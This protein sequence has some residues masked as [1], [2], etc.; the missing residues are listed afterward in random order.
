[1]NY[2]RKFSEISQDFSIRSIRGWVSGGN[3]NEM[4]PIASYDA[5]GGDPENIKPVKDKDGKHSAGLTTPGKFK[6]HHAGMHV[7]NSWNFSKVKWGVR[8]KESPAT[9]DVLY[10]D[11]P[12]QWHSVRKKLFGE[13][14]TAKNSDVIYVLMYLYERIAPNCPTRLPSTW[15]F[16]DFGHATWYMVKVNDSPETE[17]KP[18]ARQM[19]LSKPVAPPRPKIHNEFIHTTQ[20]NEYQ[21]SHLRRVILE[22]SHGCI[23]VKP[24][25]IDEMAEKG[26]L[27][28]GNWFIVHKYNEKPSIKIN[29]AAATKYSRFQLHFFPGLELIV[30]CG[31]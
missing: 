28:V 8:I 11:P 25:D 29:T 6:L 22:Y 31:Y 5:K 17:S 23:H 15:I 24:H 4:E 2:F 19:L 16:N 13:H 20:R 3:I 14:A 18:K 1:M 26:Y 10:E 27:K 7:S 9:D 21:T 30:V 12:G